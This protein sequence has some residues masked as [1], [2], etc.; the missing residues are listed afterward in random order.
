LP[1]L[2]RYLPSRELPDEKPTGSDLISCTHHHIT[3]REEDGAPSPT[4]PSIGCHPNHNQ[5]CI[6]STDLNLTFDIWNVTY[7]NINQL[8]G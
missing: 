3:F 8:K 6:S 7:V 4:K 2:G 5:N 1:H